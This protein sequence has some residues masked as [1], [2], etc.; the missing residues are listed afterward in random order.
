MGFTYW[1]ADVE[2]KPAK[3]KFEQLQK[4]LTKN[5]AKFKVRRTSAWGRDRSELAGSEAPKN[6]LS[7]A[8]KQNRRAR[9]SLNRS[10]ATQA[11]DPQAAS[12]AARVE[13]DPSAVAFNWREAGMM[14]PVRDQKSCGSCWAFGAI[15]AYEGSARIFAHRSVDLSEQHMVTCGRDDKGRDAGSCL[16]GGWLS[17]AFDQLTKRGGAGEEA[18]PYKGYGGRCDKDTETPYEAV[19]WGYVSEKAEVPSTD[20]MKAALCR[21]GPIGASVYVNDSFT[22]YA[23][24]IFDDDTAEGNESNHVITIV[25]W[26]DDKRAYLVRNSWGTD[27][28]VDGYAWVQYGTNNIGKGAAWIVPAP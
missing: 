9:K 26:D 2:A 17:S 27:W 22:A 19:T 12:T 3:S 18:L 23:S 1:P 21:Y 4:R 8:K 16:L 11:T 25:G 24:G 7:R 15:A 6:L 14:P 5:K 13:C 28:G 20:Q 10:Q